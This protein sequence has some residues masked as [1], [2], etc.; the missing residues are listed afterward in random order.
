[1]ERKGREKCRFLSFWYFE[2]KSIKEKMRAVRSLIKVVKKC[3]WPFIN[4][5][6]PNP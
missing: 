6:D 3:T 2:I 1:M 4:L 5:R